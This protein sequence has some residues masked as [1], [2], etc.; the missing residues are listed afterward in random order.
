MKQLGLTIFF[1]FGVRRG[2]HCAR[3][4]VT[5]RQVLL[6]VDH[7]VRWKVEMFHKEEKF[8][9]EVTLLVWVTLQS[10][11]LHVLMSFLSFS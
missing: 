5:I 1:V 7:N 3:L 4:Y 8:Q 2:F 6:A 11:K 9:G 10:S